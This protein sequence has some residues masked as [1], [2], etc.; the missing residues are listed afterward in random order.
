MPSPSE[1]LQTDFV[2]L[3]R[4]QAPLGEL[5]TLPRPLVVR[6]FLLSAIAASHLRC[7]QFLRL[8]RS[9]RLY[10]PSSRPYTYASH[11]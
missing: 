10:T 7:L 11:A 6:G 1:G 4:P 5:T 2:L 9:G 8:A 3:T